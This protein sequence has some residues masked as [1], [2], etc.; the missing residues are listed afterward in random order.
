MR[1]VKKP[2][3]DEIRQLSWPNVRPWLSCKPL[4]YL[5]RRCV[6]RTGF[7]LA[8]SPTSP[9]NTAFSVILQLQNCPFESRWTRGA[10]LGTGAYATVYRCTEKSGAARTGAVKVID[11]KKLSRTQITALLTEV[12]VLHRIVHPHSCV[13]VRLDSPHRAAHGC[14][15]S[16]TTLK[17]S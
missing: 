15:Q 5:C 8:P 12:K 2:T 9:L 4:S 7:P 3:T 13:S 1:T 11:Q 14:R 6:A 16:S 17:C 10:E